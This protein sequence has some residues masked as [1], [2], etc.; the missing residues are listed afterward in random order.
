[1]MPWNREQ[2]GEILAAHFQKDELS[3]LSCSERPVDMSVFY[4]AC[5]QWQWHLI[6]IMSDRMGIVLLSIP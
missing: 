3:F 6:I 2:G 4:S 1:M 5:F